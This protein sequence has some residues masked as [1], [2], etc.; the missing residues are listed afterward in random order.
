LGNSQ[1]IENLF[2]TLV[3]NMTHSYSYHKILMNTAVV[4]TQFYNR[5]SDSGFTYFNTRN[6]LIS[7]SIFL[8]RFTL[9]FN[10]SGASNQDYQLY[11]LEGKVQHTL[12]KAFTL[13][14]GIKYNKQTTY[15]IEQMGYSAEAILHLNKLGQLQFSA[16]KGFVPGMNKQ[17]VPD[18]TGRLTYLKTF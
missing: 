17:L 2:Y 16:D 11:L 18:N 4:Y 5:S 13:G 14:A 10:A 8:N 6:L 3:G 15:N 7:Q 12:S 1:Y 9:Q